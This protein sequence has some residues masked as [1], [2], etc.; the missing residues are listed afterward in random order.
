MRLDMRILRGPDWIWIDTE[1]GRRRRPAEDDRDLQ[2]RARR[3]LGVAPTSGSCPIV[4]DVE[5]DADAARR[6]ALVGR[7]RARHLRPHVRRRRRDRPRPARRRTPP[8]RTPSASAS[9]PGIP[10]YGL[11]MDGDTIPQEAGINERAVSFTQGLLR[12]PGDRGAPLLQGQAEP[13]SA[14]LKLS[15]A[16]RPRP[17]DRAWR[18]RGG[19]DRLRLRLPHPRADSARAGPARG[20]PGRHR[21]R[22]GC[23]RRGRRAPVRLKARP[24]TADE[25]LGT[26]QRAQAN[27]ADNPPRGPGLRPGGG[28]VAAGP[29]GRPAEGRGVARRG[30][31]AARRS[32]RPHRP[33]LSLA[34]RELSTRSAIY[35]A[36]TASGRPRCSHGRPTPAHRGRALH[37]PRGRAAL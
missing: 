27:P 13:T 37:G 15:R 35:A 23:R 4:G 17:G 3:D 9:R 28:R 24:R 12:R 36:T 31:A 18:A 2:P 26:W 33:E 7:G 25:V 10:R 29:F 32:R 34:L 8:R 6:G 20:R 22:R 5:L 30:R 1:P 14:R 11:D 16:G 21:R 19:P